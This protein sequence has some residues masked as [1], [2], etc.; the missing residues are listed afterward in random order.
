MPILFGRQLFTDYQ[1][2]HDLLVAM[3]KREPGATPEALEAML[4][5]IRETVVLC[6]KD[7]DARRC[8][9]SVITY[10]SYRFQAWSSTWDVEPSEVRRLLPAAVTGV[11]PH[12]H[13]RFEA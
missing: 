1:P 7:L 13:V 8:R 2:L 10:F 3:E 6:F 11:A 12:G 9:S 5:G 4:P